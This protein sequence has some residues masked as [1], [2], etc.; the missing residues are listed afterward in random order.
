[1]LD[2][3]TDHVI[4][5]KA[6]VTGHKV[7]AVIGGAAV[8][9]VQVG[10]AGQAGGQCTGQAG[11]TPPILSD[12]IAEFVVPFGPASTREVTHLVTANIP[13]LG[14]EFGRP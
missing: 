1:M 11:I 6:I 8:G 13:R 14:N 9:V 10:A 2:I 3:V 12:L 4:Q 7:D 5:G